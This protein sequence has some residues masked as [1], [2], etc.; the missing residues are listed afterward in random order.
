M[1]HNWLR[2]PGKEFINQSGKFSA[3]KWANKIRI[4]S[5][6]NPDL[7][8]CR[9]ALIGVEDE[10]SDIL[11]EHIYDLAAPS[12]DTTVAD[13][14]NLIKPSPESLIQVVKECIEGDII[15]IILSS[16]SLFTHAQYK[17]YRSS[18]KLVNLALIHERIPYTLKKTEAKF[19]Q[20]Y[21]NEVLNDKSSYLFHLGMLGYQSHYNDPAVI[22]SLT[23]RHFDLLRLG[24]MKSFIED[25][26]PMIRD[27]DLLSFDISVLKQ[28]EAPGCGSASPSGI[29][30][31]EACQ[32]AHFAGLSDKLSSAGFY[33]FDPARDIH[34]QSAKL[35]AQMVW[36]FVDG[37]SNRDKDFPMHPSRFLKYTVEL[38]SSNS[39]LTFWKS[40]KSDRWWIQVPNVNRKKE[41]RHRL[42]PCS[43]KDYQQACREELPDRYLNAC[44]RFN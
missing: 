11:R 24:R 27:A 21:L 4:F 15:P 3:Y 32:L 34:H 23:E 40:K 16:D 39:S 41:Q 29:F 20:Y 8:G 36:Y 30:S 17:A 12:A 14:G 10:A 42:I 38:K 22:D 43:V 44:K 33:G 1:L 37:I 35:I 6:N 7:K 13:L 19:P 26:E 18:Q 2:P 9:V 31:E 5:K 25:A 28:S